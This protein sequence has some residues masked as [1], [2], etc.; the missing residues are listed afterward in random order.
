[1]SRAWH[2][3]TVRGRMF[4]IAGI[5]VVLIAMSAGQRDVM[6]IGLLLVTLPVIAG[7]LIAQARLRMSCERAVEPAQVPLG[8]PMKVRSC[9]PGG[10]L[11]AGIL[12]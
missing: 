8:S 4:L 10:S 1:M 12:S 2:L 5:V 11:P 9:G 6:R 3:L 7:I